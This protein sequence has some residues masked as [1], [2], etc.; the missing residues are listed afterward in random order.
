MIADESKQVYR[1]VIFHLSLLGMVTGTV[2]GFSDVLFHSI[3]ESVHLFMEMLEQLLDNLIEHFLHVER[4]ETQ[5]IVFY[6]LLIFGGVMTLFLWKGFVVL[7]QW[8]F[9][10]VRGDYSELKTVVADDWSALSTIDKILWVSLTIAV[11]Y[12]ASYLFF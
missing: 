4:R 7:C 8:F 2:V 12:L 1:R 9:E 6:I 5:I 3:I 11:N 10:V